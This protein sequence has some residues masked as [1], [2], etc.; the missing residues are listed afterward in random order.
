MTKKMSQSLPDRSAVAFDG[1]IG[2]DTH[3][4]AVF[5]TSPSIHLSA[6]NV[7]LLAM[8][9]MGDG[10]SL[11]GDDHVDYLEFVYISL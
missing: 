10:D 7:L 4:V 11:K 8:A 6:Y 1:W 3:S 9:P 5:A 2:G